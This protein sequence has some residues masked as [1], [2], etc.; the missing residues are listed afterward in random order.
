MSILGSKAA[1]DVAMLV[2]QY[3]QQRHVTDK[4]IKE[5][6]SKEEMRIALIEFYKSQGIDNVTPEMIDDGIKAYEKNRFTFNGFK[7]SSLSA[8]IA[9]AFVRAYPS[10]FMLLI[11]LI[12]TSSIF[13]AGI[14]TLNKVSASMAELKIST[15][16][17]SASSLENSINKRITRNRDFLLSAS[18]E[19]RNISGEFNY[20]KSFV[21]IEKSELQKL[22]S[23]A[24]SINKMAHKEHSR[25]S[26]EAKAL[27]E[28]SEEIDIEKASSNIV[29]SYSL[30]VEPILKS[31]DASES[32]IR[33]KLENLAKIKEAEKD[34][35]VIEKSSLFIQSK[36]KPQVSS[37]YSS[38]VFEIATGDGGA[39]K[40]LIEK[41]KLALKG[42]LEKSFPTKI[43]NKAQTETG[44]KKPNEDK[45]NFKLIEGDNSIKPM[46][47]ELVENTV[48]GGNLE[49][50]LA[51]ISNRSALSE[52]GKEAENI[53]DV[54]VNITKALLSIVGA[55][56][57]AL[58]MYG[59]HK[60][61][62][63]G[64]NRGSQKAI[65]RVILG[66]A[67]LGAS[68]VL[69]MML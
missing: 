15:A 13:L 64:S 3:R 68:P 40:G 49:D 2:E 45:L 8:L 18:D 39:A 5:H 42:G 7:G 60:D 27:M 51:L 24:L 9:K 52:A 25:I 14:Y 48:T 22:I 46:P 58:G 63:T 35:S 11:V 29:M 62:S 21:S 65:V 17:D 6:E 41:L 33:S 69:N 12:V 44:N 55:F 54:M 31:A 38:A 56:I 50:K 67:L 43:Q 16:I 1:M 47:K 19:S 10:R 26:E 37:A 61:M 20:S 4:Y 59:L 66:A 36:E 53:V 34:I 23:D 28:S 30:E 57:L 32:I